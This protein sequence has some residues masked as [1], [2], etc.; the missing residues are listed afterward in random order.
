MAAP[1]HG[2]GQE[3]GPAATLT[4]SQLQHLFVWSRPFI[5]LCRLQLCATLRPLCFLIAGRGR[6][7]SEQC[8]GAGGEMHGSVP[9]NHSSPLCVAPIMGRGLPFFFFPC[10]APVLF[11]PC[12]HIAALLT[13]P[14]RPPHLNPCFSPF[15]ISSA[16]PGWETG[17]SC[18]GTASLSRVALSRPS[19]KHTAT[20]YPGNRLS[21]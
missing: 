9:E 18:R 14:S 6:S 11:I 5:F 21:F 16:S 3:F 12:W 15:L 19:P 13:P 7:S 1:G 8:R 2:G 17:H 20:S 4:P 10:Y